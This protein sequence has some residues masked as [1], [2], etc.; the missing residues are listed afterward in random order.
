MTE[1]TTASAKAKT[2]KHAAAWFGLSHY[3]IPKFEMPS[4]ELPE[5][6]REMTD[7]NVAQTR[8]TYAKAKAASEEAADLLK[9]VYATAARSA[10]AYNLKLPRSHVPTPV[11]PLTTPMS[12]WVLSPRRSFSR[13]RRRRCASNSISLPRRI[14]NLSRSSGRS[15]PRLPSRLRKVCQTRPIRPSDRKPQGSFAA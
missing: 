11:R 13:C 9:N 8:D 5:A 3:G 12:F 14:R 1:A 15:R 4:M 2:T 6:L 7:K 10:T